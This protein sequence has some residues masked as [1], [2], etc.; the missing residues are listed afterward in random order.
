MVIFAPI[1][2][3]GCLK[4]CANAFINS[5]ATTKV[6][7]LAKAMVF[8][9]LIA[10]MV[11]R[12][13]AYPTIEAKTIS[14]GCDSTIWQSASAPAYTLIGKSLNAS[15]SWRYFSS[16]AITTASGKNLRACSISKSTRLLAVNAYASYKSGCSSI[17][18]KACVPIDPVEPNI[19]ICFFIIC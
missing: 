14:I 9:A 10:F 4:A 7:L 16:L 17:T 8:P 1:S 6:S 15:F 3:L 2:Q 13:P 5:P 12:N 19:A 11:G 18:C